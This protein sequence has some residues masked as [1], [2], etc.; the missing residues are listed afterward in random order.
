MTPDSRGYVANPPFCGPL[1][2]LS[3]A[4][5]CCPPPPLD[6]RSYEAHPRTC[7]PL[8]ILSPTVKHWGPHPLDGRG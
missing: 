5:K 6:G 3:P 7:G 2:I 4:V 1:L 8:P